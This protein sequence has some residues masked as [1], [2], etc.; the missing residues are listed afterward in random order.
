MTFNTG[1]QAT[2][3]GTGAESATANGINRKTWYVGSS[4]P[5]FTVDGVTFP[6]NGTLWLDS[7][8]TPPT[9]K[10]YNGTPWKPFD[11]EDNTLTLT[12]K[13][14]NAT[15]NTITDTSTAADDLLKSNG[16]KFVR[17]AKGSNNT[18]LRVNNS[19]SLEYDEILGNELGRN[20]LGGEPSGGANAGNCGLPNGRSKLHRSVIS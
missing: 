8:T 7:S 1:T 4:A 11:T 13:T 6:E 14:I 12:N 16:T 10:I 3:G 5:S 15:N 9:P 18:F 19:G 17:F 20:S 2:V